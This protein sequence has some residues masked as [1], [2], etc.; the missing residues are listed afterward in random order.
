M[1]P[2]RVAAQAKPVHL[3]IG[4]Y[5]R[6]NAEG[7]YIYSFDPKTAELK[8]ES[9]IKGVSN[10]SYLA[11]SPNNKF[12]YSVEESNGAGAKVSAFAFNAQTGAATYLNSRPSGGDG[13][14]YVSV[15]ETGSDVFVGN[16]GGGTLS[17][18]HVQA[19]GSLDS[20]AQTIVH[21]GSSVNKD[22][23]EKPHVHSVVLSPDNHYL[24]VPDLG[25]DK[26]M[27]YR[28]DPAANQPLTP[29]NPPAA[30]VKPGAGPRHIVFHPNGKF[31]YVTEEM[32]GSV[33]VFS[34]ASGKLNPVQSVSMLP[35]GFKGQIGAA[36]IHLSPDGKFLYASNRGDANEI[37]IYSIQPGSGM[38]KWVGRQSAFGKTPRNFVIDPTGNF[39]LVANQNTGNIFVFKRDA[40]TGLLTL[41]KSKLDI[42]SP[43]CLKF[44]SE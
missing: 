19:D 22:R 6:K 17:V 1:L 28:F 36:D 8:Q 5:T 14:C 31:A 33:A 27:I 3:L 21:Q 30:A 37:V 4:T 25:L 16:Y 24:M 29:A 40:R 43:V 10:P 12:L 26:V 42:D 18:L 44:V 38:L 9:A 34:Y 15:S 35:V 13:P 41:T 32:A 20:T 7:I 23:Q 39:L 2:L 11:V